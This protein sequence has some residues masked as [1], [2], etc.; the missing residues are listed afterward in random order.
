MKLKL[1][2][3]DSGKYLKIFF[4]VIL[5][6]FF[7][8]IY[9]NVLV[10]PKKI[11]T[12]VNSFFS[13]E[14]EKYSENYNLT[15]K[16]VVALID[17]D[18]NFKLFPK[19][20]VSISNIKFENIFYKNISLG[21]DIHD[22][23]MELKFIPLI[24]GRVK[25]K[26]ISIN[27]SDFNVNINKL[28]TEYKKKVIEDKVVDID[29]NEVDGIGH[30][31]KNII[32][33]DEDKEL[34]KNGKKIIQAEVEKTVSI[35]NSELSNMLVDTFNDFDKKFLKSNGIKGT[36]L[37]IDNI[38]VTLYD[39]GRIIKEIS[40]VRG[41]INFRNRKIISN[42]IYDIEQET[43]NS[44]ITY[45]VNRSGNTNIN[46]KFKSNNVIN[47]AVLNFSGKIDDLFNINK[48]S[49]I[50]NTSLKVTN[51]Y[52]FANIIGLRY[53]SD[54]NNFMLNKSNKDVFNIS[55]KIELKDGLMES[56]NISI[57]SN[58]L[59]LNVNFNKKG[60][61][62]K[63]YGD[64]GFL[65][66]NNVFA[67]VE[68]YSE[69]NP[70]TK[71]SIL[72]FNSE[73]N[74]NSLVNK[75]N[76]NILNKSNTKIDLVINNN[77]LIYNG[78]L[79][80]NNKVDISISNNGISFNK[81]E[82]NNDDYSVNISNPKL[83][84]D[85]YVNDFSIHLSRSKR[86]S[87]YF[88]W[89]KDIDKDN[90]FDITGNL[91][92]SNDILIFLN[93]SIKS[94][95]NIIP[96]SLEHYFGNTGKKYTAIKLVTNECEFKYDNKDDSVKQKLLFLSDLRNNLYLDLTSN[97]FRFN[98]I[99]LLNFRTSL[100]TSA[101]YLS[102]NNLRFDSESLKNFSGDLELD[103]TRNL[104]IVNFNFTATNYSKKINIIPYLIN[105]EK[106]QK[107]LG[108]EKSDKD[109]DDY[110]VKKFFKIAS[111]EGVNGT[112][113]GNIG[114][115]N[116]NNVSINKFGFDL[117]L[118]NGNF[119]IN[120][121][122]CELQDGN[123][124]LT[125]SISIR[126]NDRSINIKADKNI[127]SLI[128]LNRLITR[129]NDSVLSG[130]IGVGGYFSASGGNISDFSSSISSY[131]EFVGNNV[132]IKGFG[133]SDLR[134]KLSNIHLKKDILFDLN[135]KDALINKDTGTMFKKVNG[136]FYS[137]LNVYKSEMNC[138]G[139]GI[140]NKFNLSINN[141]DNRTII[142]MVNASA[143]V[144]L[145]NKT[146]IPLYTYISYKENVKDKAT[147]DF[148]LSNVDEY[149]E[150]VREKVEEAEHQKIAKEKER[151]RK[152]L[153]EK[154]KEEEFINTEGRMIKDITENLSM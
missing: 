52:D 92:I 88:S 17:G 130:L 15:N 67:R 12:E 112:I 117:S 127:Y 153:L 56:N 91:I 149:L 76:K 132:Y 96:F 31:I 95:G 19:P 26:D 4:A 2:I 147:L 135:P 73:D 119:N 27:S 141:S 3:N 39:E 151:E 55:G 11:K 16:K 1:E 42:L 136:K 94:N 25:A 101:G 103:I 36:H 139:D 45:A 29:K 113:K 38:S 78:I 43:I 65:N 99:D 53:Q 106:Y 47:N 129:S 125:G 79:F 9:I 85:V 49:G 145:V 72:I 28:L 54:N 102:L 63:V 74:I 34:E 134:E 110:W 107:I 126:D 115:L 148:N 44:D 131:F 87:D 61:N 70:N 80:K 58:N 123:V 86:I 50:L 6:I 13:A 30:K 90:E 128:D 20:V 57:D 75:L 122:D 68:K 97:R 142:D 71:D 114:Y 108:G 32:G 23:K 64:L 150:K 5:S 18:V 133:L 35:D 51:I 59:K 37:N 82:L 105:L 104:P 138:S 7:F 118:D 33:I 140:S 10:N 62:V 41:S 24:F 152:N 100:K 111:F 81:L 21:S 98:G 8:F 137:Q 14:I 83:I 48:W 60:D 69:F 124:N 144:V 46:L 120:K 109:L 143:M 84:Q 116:I 40:G 77:E 22:V 66:F 121:F 146:K 93:S 154:Q 89:I